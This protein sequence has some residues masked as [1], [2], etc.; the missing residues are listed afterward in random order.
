MAMHTVLALPVL[1]NKLHVAAVLHLYI[2]HLP[3]RV[4]LYMHVDIGVLGRNLGVLIW[5][6][7]IR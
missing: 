7:I 1:Q 2:K 4:I 3:M 5:F 6:L